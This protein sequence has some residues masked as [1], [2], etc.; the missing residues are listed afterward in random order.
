MHI[1][2][3]VVPYQKKKNANLKEVQIKLLNHYN[4]IYKLLPNWIN[5]KDYLKI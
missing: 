1:H 3:H 4:Q 5:Q 2:I